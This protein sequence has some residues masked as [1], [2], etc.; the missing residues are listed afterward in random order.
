MYRYWSIEMICQYVSSN[1]MRWTINT[2]LKTLIQNQVK[3]IERWNLMLN[4]K[5]WILILNINTPLVNI[6]LLEPNNV[7]IF[8]EENTKDVSNGHET[9]KHLIQVG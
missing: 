6:C 5:R 9:T 8:W 1:F 3:Q 7:C 4:F 2:N